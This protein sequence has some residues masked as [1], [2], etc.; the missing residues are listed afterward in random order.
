MEKLRII[1]GGFI[2]L[3]PSGGITWDYMQYP[4][5]FSLLGHDVYY[6][7]DT[8]LFPLYQP[9]GSD[10]G[11]ASSSVNYLKGVME[12]FGFKDRWAYRDEASG[13]SFGLSEYKIKQLCQ[14]ADVFINVS[15]STCIRP[16]YQAIPV[17]MLIDSD[18]MFTQIQYE[19]EQMFTP[20]KPAL[21]E[22]IKNHTHFFTFGE[23]IGRQDCKI[24]ECGIKWQPTRQPV[25]LSHWKAGIGSNKLS[26]NFTTLMNWA[27]GK[28]LEYNGE[29]WGQKDIEFQKVLN[30]P[31]LVKDI[32][33]SAVVNQT[34]IV[35]HSLSKAEVE[36]AGWKILSPE[37]AGDWQSYQQFI[38][39][40]DGEFSVAKNTYVKAATG[41]FSC[42]S[43]CYL[44][45]GKP[46]VTQDTGWSKNIPS[47]AGLFAFTDMQTAKEA[48]ESIMADYNY[49]CKK[50][51]Q[52][53]EEYF[54][55]ETV[56]N[57]LLLNL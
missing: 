31:Q 11:D 42:R 56:L 48:L 19:S 20:G 6:I 1:V 54:D 47:G 22:L 16:E 33:F 7:E 43:A 2:G 21:Q 8:R 29:S 45:S 9:P 53:A 27:A 25:C 18:P 30:L 40:S 39:G 51:R 44:A 28:K 23:N 14:S 13:K 3:L 38:T 35:G 10:W 41:W 17:R 12:A 26:Y 52:V 46:V 57:N 37:L 5:G 24:P 50:A 34:D 4:L 15:C 49:H 55:S 36:K 32:R